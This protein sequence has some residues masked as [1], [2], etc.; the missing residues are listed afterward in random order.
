[1]NDSL[2][3]FSSSTMS[4]PTDFNKTI[5][6][7]SMSFIS[8]C[9]MNLIIYSDSNLLNVN[10]AQSSSLMVSISLLYSSPFKNVTCQFGYLYQRI[11]K[12]F[13]TFNKIPLT[14]CFL[15]SSMKA[16]KSLCYWSTTVYFYYST[17]NIDEHSAWSYYSL[18][19]Y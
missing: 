9:P 13:F 14:N 12:H 6:N 7:Y 1:M 16:I 11:S 5:D 19:I 2:M 17:Y 4:F 15:K 8:P 3:I 10:L 18:N